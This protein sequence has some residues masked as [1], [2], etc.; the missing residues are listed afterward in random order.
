MLIEV[1]D[2]LNAIPADYLLALALV[3]WKEREVHTGGL[4]GIYH[5]PSGS[6]D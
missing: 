5:Q 2:E 1:G 3:S 4:S 6:P